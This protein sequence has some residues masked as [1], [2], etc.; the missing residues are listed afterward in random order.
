[1]SSNINPSNNDDG[2][3]RKRSRK[4][5]K[6]P[7]NNKDNTNF[8]YKNVSFHERTSSGRPGSPHRYFEHS[9]NVSFQDHVGDVDV[10][11]SL[12]G[13]AAMKP[14]DTAPAEAS[15]S[16]S[17]AAVDNADSSSQSIT[18]P[19]NNNSTG[20]QVVHRHVNGL[21]IITAGNILQTAL[22]QQNSTSSDNNNGESQHQSIESIKYLVKVAPD[23]QSAKGKL[24]AKN[25]KR[26]KNN[27]NNKND[28]SVAQD[29][30]SGDV[31]PTDALCEVTLTNGE[32]VTLKCCV[33]GTII[34]LNHRLAASES[35]VEQHQQQS[36][37]G[38]DVDG[39]S[40]IDGNASLLLT[41][42]LLDGYL[43]VIMPNRGTHLPTL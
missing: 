34:E 19:S 28:S 20:N 29:A 17:T 38:A 23:A 13:S 33:Q 42:P 41:D 22:Q 6:G 36:S 40:N 11:S 7:S 15:A 8:C 12:S 25:K 14:D 16:A 30:N 37:N 43:A 39:G 24:R 5:V 32:K 27:N 21:C 10:S 9:Y 3:S 1:M 18:V 4:S 31:T 35:A 2:P 26:K